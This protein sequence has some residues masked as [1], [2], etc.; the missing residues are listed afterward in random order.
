MPDDTA[1]PVLIY[2]GEC[3]FCRA[4]VDFWHSLTGDSLEYLP[5][6][7]AS[8]R[9][10]DVPLEDCRK[11]VQF[12]TPEGRFPG[13]EGVCRFLAGVPGYSWLFWCYRF[14]PGFALLAA[15]TYKFVAN[16][17]SP[18]W[19]ITR[20]LWGEHIGRPTYH[21]ASEVFSRALSIVYFIAFLSFGLQV[22]GLIGSEGILPAR[23]FLSAVHAQLGNVSWWRL[24]TL[25]WWG[26]ADVT[27]LSITWGG[28][29]LSLFSLL[30]R[31]HSKWQRIIFAVLWIYYL[32]IVNAG[33]VFM[34]FQWDW[35]LVEA[36]FIAIFLQPVN[37]RIWLFRWLAFRLTFE[38]G[39]VKLLS[40]DP[41]WHNLTALNFH[42]ET[43]PLPTPLAWYMHLAPDWFQK[44]SVGGVFAI[45]L[46][47]PF[48]MFGPRRMKRFAG[49]GLIAF[50]VLI[51]LTG[52]YTF[53]NLLTIALCLFLFDDAFFERWWKKGVERFSWGRFNAAPA[54]G[55]GP[56]RLVSVG[57]WTLVLFLS[58]VEL[59][60]TVGKLPKPVAQVA[61]QLSQFGFVNHY[62][63][64]AV[65]TTKRLEIQVEGSQDGEH[66]EPYLF[67]Y[68]PGP[69]NRRPAWVEPYQ[70]RLDWQMWFAALGNVREN[71]WFIR[72]MVGLLRGSR[73]IAA[74][75]QAT[76]FEG[77]P[78]KFV[79]AT[80]YEY[81]FTTWDERQKT[82][83][84]WKSEIKGLYFPPV[85]LRAGQ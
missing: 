82:G 60:A 42:Y 83:N 67:P 15:W 53:F 39:V 47:L 54:A 22:R 27:L 40:G 84:Y 63:L 70:P 59:A 57:L 65:M 74:L 12:I 2:D 34:S 8:E 64:F 7:E 51:V 35:L 5:F 75:F 18:G 78:P 11:A 28:V 20:A 43:Q 25:F 16:H 26:D 9:F 36:G 4:W 3:S 38:S 31:A 62:G 6:Q 32:S 48:L 49:I 14:V 69:L 76:P 19:R 77:V 41:S 73:P 13:A 55:R 80:I 21:T 33:Q 23:E 46:V 68:K 72:M 30:T 24:P 17:R 10:P 58:G 45:E 52:N 37:S 81:H 1:R 44:I 56:R 66:W 50:Q 71:P 61:Q 79:R 29:A 85:G